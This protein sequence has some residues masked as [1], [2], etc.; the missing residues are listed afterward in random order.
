[1]PI[2]TFK[3]T[4]LRKRFILITLTQATNTIITAAA[5]N[6]IFVFVTTKV[7][8]HDKIQVS[9]MEI[10]TILSSYIGN[11]SIQTEY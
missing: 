10:T 9:Y 2:T 11:E 8:Y 4:Y 6:F 7:D 5:T 3:K 1:M